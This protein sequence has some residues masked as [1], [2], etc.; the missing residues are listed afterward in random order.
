MLREMLRSKIHRVKVTEINLNY[1]G[2]I[3]IDRKLL[4]AASILPYEK[5]QVV[6]INNGSRFETYVMEG[7]R[8][9]EICVNG[10]AARLAQPGDLLIIMAYGFFTDE[11]AKNWHPRLVLV[12][13][14]NRIVK[15]S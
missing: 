5:V 8:E 6:N 3:T 7:E 15:Q 11:E 10:A 2:S 1:V 9:G 4:E 14:Y 12:D 13:D